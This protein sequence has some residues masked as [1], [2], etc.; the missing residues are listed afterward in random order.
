MLSDHL[1]RQ[2]ISIE[3][4]HQKL[5]ADRDGTV[6]EHEWIE[7]VAR[8]INF[9]QANLTQENLRQIFKKIDV[10]GDG[11]LTVNEL[12]YYISGAKQDMHARISRIPQHQLDEIR[13]ETEKVFN[14]F[15]TKRQNW[16]TPQDF[17]TALS[18]IQPNATNEYIQGLIDKI[19]TNK[20]GRI[21]KNE[22]TEFL[23]EEATKKLV[24]QDEFIEEMR[25]KFKNADVDRS[26]FLE[27]DEFYSVILDMG[28]G[29]TREE[30]ISMFADID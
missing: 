5:D 24:Q 6:D 21:D 4:F 1:Q 28:S 2:N 22:F 27:F 3:E 29:V 26:G 11:S 25:N 13:R 23:M 30:V 19:D 14:D 12:A 10:D 20:D 16:V 15:D 18:R 8:I 17:K 9:Q 7:G